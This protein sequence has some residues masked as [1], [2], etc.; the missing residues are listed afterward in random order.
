M[1]TGSSASPRGGRSSSQGTVDT[2]TT[3]NGIPAYIINI[4]HPSAAGPGPVKGPTSSDNRVM[5]AHPEPMIFGNLSAFVMTIDIV[6]LPSSTSFAFSFSLPFKLFF[7]F[8]SAR[9]PALPAPLSLRMNVSRLSIN[10]ASFPSSRDI[11]ADH[12][13]FGV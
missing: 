5:T 2:R 12:R 4:Q 8:P 11:I 10:P 13:I 6:R 9:P 7:M 3:D 1:C